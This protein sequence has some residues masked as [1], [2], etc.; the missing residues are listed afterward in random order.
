M[1]SYWKMA[2]RQEN[3]LFVD[4]QNTKGIIYSY[5]VTSQ[6]QSTRLGSLRQY[7]GL[8]YSRTTTFNGLYWVRYD[9]DNNVTNDSVGNTL[10]PQTKRVIERGK[11]CLAT[12]RPNATTYNADLIL[13]SIVKFDYYLSDTEI[14]QVKTI[15]KLQ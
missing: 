13:K 4:A 9:Y 6:D 12:L 11:L 2:L 14:E 1:V 7:K 5:S 8:L 10:S 3:T 15:L